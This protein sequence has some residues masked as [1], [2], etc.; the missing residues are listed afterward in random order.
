[1]GLESPIRRTPEKTFKEKIT[2]ALRMSLMASVMS[3]AALYALNDSKKSIIDSDFDAITVAQGK[4]SKSKESTKPLTEKEYNSLISIISVSD[5]QDALAIIEDIK[6][7]FTA[8]QYRHA[9]EELSKQAS[10]SIALNAHNLKPN[11]GAF[12]VDPSL[13]DVESVKRSL[14][15]P[16]VE[17]KADANFWLKLQQWFQTQDQ[18]ENFNRK[19]AATSKEEEFVPIKSDGIKMELMHDISEK[20]QSYNP[21]EIEEAA[22]YVTRNLAARN[23]PVRDA[24]VSLEVNHIQQVRNREAHRQL[25]AGNILL[26]A[27]GEIQGKERTFGPLALQKGLKEVQKQET[28]G[29]GKFWVVSPLVTQDRHIKVTEASMK[30]AK[31]SLFKHISF[32]TEPLT[33]FFDGHGNKDGFYLA[34]GEIGENGKPVEYSPNAKITVHELAEVLTQRFLVQKQK[35]HNANRSNVTLISGACY[36]QNF[37]RSLAQE[38][39]TRGVP[40]P[41]VMISSSEFG[42]FGFSNPADPM[43]A[44][45]NSFI[46]KNPSLG[47]VLRN[48]FS[49]PQSSKPSVFVPEKTKEGKEVLMQL[50]GLVV[51]DSSAAA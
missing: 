2:S 6:P 37:M 9:K 46:A 12:M 22:A 49:M 1:M 4:Q 33:V 42:Q 48:E 29:K 27:N 45:F 36:M 35:D 34:S 7:N 31:D 51:A 5:F 50:G 14:L 26:V 47:E 13:K 38:L 8:E 20:N 11:Y 32:S 23:E 43:G 24:T 39:Q 15:Y 30:D 19:N 41:A 25:F 40:L 28:H 3:G 18:Y 16:I 10:F 17:H 21:I 44:D